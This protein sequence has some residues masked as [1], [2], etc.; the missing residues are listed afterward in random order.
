MRALLDKWWLGWAAAITIVVGSFVWLWLAPAEPAPSRQRD[1]RAESVCLLTDADGVLG[2]AAAPV[3]AGLQQG[4]L[5]TLVKVSY[6]AVS[7]PQEVDN[8]ATFV[9][10]LV[11]GRC[12]LLVAVGEVPVKAVSASAPNFPDQRFAVVGGSAASNV[13]VL[14]GTTAAARELLTEDPAFG[15]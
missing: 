11:Q 8:A 5:E 1:Y 3:W 14:E 9:A 12:D 6:V 10:G 13:S 2:S 4:S 7:G 15:S